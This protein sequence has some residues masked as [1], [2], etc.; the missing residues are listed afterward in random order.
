MMGM[1]NCLIMM[2]IA[3]A[4]CGYPCGTVY[5][6]RNGT[7]TPPSGN[8]SINAAGLNR[9]YVLVLPGGYDGKTPWPVVLAFHGTTSNGAQFIGQYYG[10]VKNG[11][12]K[13]AIIVAPDGLNGTE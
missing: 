10:N 7:A 4:V 9:T 6:G 5:Y 8:P 13:R 3:A 12:A 11:V 1:Q 2:M